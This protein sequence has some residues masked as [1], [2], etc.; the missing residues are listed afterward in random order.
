[1]CVSAAIHD[2]Q[3]K[4]FNCKLQSTSST[5]LNLSVYNQNP[6]YKCFYSHNKSTWNYDIQMCN[7]MLGCFFSLDVLLSNWKIV[8][9]GFIYE[10]QELWSRAHFAFESLNS[11]IFICLFHIF[12]Y[13]LHGI[14]HLNWIEF[15]WLVS[16]IESN[17]KWWWRWCCSS[18]ADAYVRWNWTRCAV[19]DEKRTKHSKRK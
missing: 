17:M 8:E 12:I 5:R 6:K 3:C 10:F 2:C 9:H 19:N 4:L 1:M 7:T 11:S 13:H 15:E 14:T 16:F 18:I